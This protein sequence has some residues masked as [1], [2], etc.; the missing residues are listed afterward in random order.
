MTQFDY[1]KMLMQYIKHVMDEEGVTFI[2]LDIDYNANDFYQ[3]TGL[4][5]EEWIEIQK[6]EREGCED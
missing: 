1:R 6:I 4:T 3:Y 5:A 2:P